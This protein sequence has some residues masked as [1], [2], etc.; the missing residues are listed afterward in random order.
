MPDRIPFWGLFDLLGLFF[1]PWEQDLR[2]LLA[3][4]IGY[5]LDL[6]C[7][8]SYMTTRKRSLLRKLRTM[9]GLYNTA[10][11]SHPSSYSTNKGRKIL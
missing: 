10:N 5:M 6:G 7:K 8:L 4:P 3:Q 9:L 1:L 2:K 11:S